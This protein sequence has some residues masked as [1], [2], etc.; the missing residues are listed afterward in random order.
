MNSLVPTIYPS[1]IARACAS[2]DESPLFKTMPDG[3]L[4]VLLRIIKK[5]NLSCPFSPIFASRGTIAQESGK[6][7][8]TVHRVVKWLEDSGL[9]EREQKARAGLRGSSSPLVPTRKLLDALLLS[10]APQERASAQAS[11]PV[12]H[13]STRAQQ[14]RSAFVRVGKATLPSDIAWLSTRNGLA[15]TGVLKLMSLAKKAKQRLSDVVAATAQYL[16]GLSGRALYAYIKALLSKDKD[17][18]Y[19]AKQAESEAEVERDQDYLKE[20]AEALDGRS[21]SN[22][23]GSIQITVQEGVLMETRNGNRAVR[24]MCKSFL[25]A[26][27]AGRLR[28]SWAGVCG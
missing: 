15:P 9:I 11:K 28:P 5:I 20:K 18:G 1:H 7:I 16:E 10:Q 25:E 6:S 24:M 26:L 23:D 21:F 8:E 2:L 3:Y 4:R 13:S 27:E 12:N 17:Y 22:K 19:V 14:V